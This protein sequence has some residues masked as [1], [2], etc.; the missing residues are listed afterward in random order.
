MIC[1]DFKFAIQKQ[2]IETSLEDIL[3]QICSILGF[4]VGS[5]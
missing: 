4:L 3:S 1:C 5:Y 2:E